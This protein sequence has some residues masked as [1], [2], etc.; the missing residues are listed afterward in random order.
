M[1]YFRLGGGVFSG[2]FISW[3]FVCLSEGES[4]DNFLVGDCR[5]S[6]TVLIGIGSPNAMAFVDTL[7]LFDLRVV[8]LD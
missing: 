7:A 5:V 1:R 4:M 6:P 2:V 8:F 3:L